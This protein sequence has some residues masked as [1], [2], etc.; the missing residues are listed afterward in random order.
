MED[1]AEKEIK[2][3]F[4]NIDKGAFCLVSSAKKYYGVFCLLIRFLKYKAVFC[5]IPRTD[6]LI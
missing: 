2:V 4:Y 1:I 6:Y 5:V 3:A